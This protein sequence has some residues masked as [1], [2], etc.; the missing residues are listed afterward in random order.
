MKIPKFNWS[1]LKEVVFMVIGVA[2]IV[3]LLT[4]NSALQDIT[5]N[6]ASGKVRNLKAR[7]EDCRLQLGLGLPVSHNCTE[8]DMRPYFDANEHIDT[9]S[10]TI[11]CHMAKEIKPITLPDKCKEL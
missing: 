11:L 3:I 6:Q 10:V 1:V 8:K 9:A 7:A 5:A 4:I 2:L